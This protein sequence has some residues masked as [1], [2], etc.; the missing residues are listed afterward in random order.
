[1][2]KSLLS[3]MEALYLVSKVVFYLLIWTVGVHYL[4][5]TEFTSAYIWLTL[6]GIVGGALWIT[7]PMMRNKFAKDKKGE[8][9]E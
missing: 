6:S 2:N 3:I 1:M 4:S 7:L 5:K 8:G 9:K